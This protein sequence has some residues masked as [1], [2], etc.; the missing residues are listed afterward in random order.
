MSASEAVLKKSTF[1]DEIMKIISNPPVYLQEIEAWLDVK[2][3]HASTGVRLDQVTDLIHLVSILK[4]KQCSNY[5]FALQVYTAERTSA[6]SQKS[7]ITAIMMMP[8]Q[9]DKICELICYLAQENALERYTRISHLPPIRFY[10]DNGRSNECRYDE[11]KEWYLLFELFSLCKIAPHK[12]I[13]LIARWLTA[14]TPS[15]Q[16]IHAFLKLLKIMDEMEVLHYEIIETITPYLK[17]Q[18]S[19]EKINLFLLKLQRNNLLNSE[20]FEHAL[21]LLKHL[22]AL[23]TFFTF[24]EDELKSPPSRSSILQRLRPYCQM[25]LPAKKSYDDHVE[26]NTPL[27]QAVLEGNA[28]NLELTL[29]FANR[30]LLAHT[31]YE[32]TALVLACKIANKSAAKR[33]LA[34]MQEF[35]CD[36]NQADHHGMTALHWAKFYHFDDLV[37]DLMR[38]GANDKLKTKSGENCD[39]FYNHRFKLNDFKIEGP[40]IIEDAFKLKNAAL[41]DLCFHMDKIALNLKLASQIEIDDLYASS[42]TAQY[43]S[44]NRFQ[45]FFKTLRSRLINWLEEQQRLSHQSNPASA[46]LG[47]V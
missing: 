45:L 7:L 47:L 5:V 38:A 26:A 33:I 10:Q 2:L 36:V 1:Y 3:R 35:E 28:R 15:T 44:A 40:E 20:V 46:S 43:R 8:G 22:S 16:D 4:T 12:A 17:N 6:E 18:A 31:S 32:N 24:Y 13:P 9:D 21:P 25:L 41:T 23:D 11:Y 29:S 30:K 34:K 19:I 14:N 27:H 42:D 39:Y 37:S